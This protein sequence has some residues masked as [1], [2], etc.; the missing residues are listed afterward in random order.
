MYFFVFF[1]VILQAFLTVYTRYSNR[2]VLAKCIE[3]KRKRAKNGYLHAN[4]SEKLDSYIQNK[5]FRA[6]SQ[7]FFSCKKRTLYKKLYKYPL[8]LHIAAHEI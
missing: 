4:L 2:R 1:T 8:V 3:Q 5:I 6:Y 7:L